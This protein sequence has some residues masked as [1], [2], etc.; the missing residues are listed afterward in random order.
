MTFGRPTLFF[1]TMSAPNAE[2]TR[3]R[4]E[5]E[6]TLAAKLRLEA[7]LDA[8]EARLRA[9]HV[10]LKVSDKE[11]VLAHERLEE[12]RAQLAEAQARADGRDTDALALLNARLQSAEAANAAT[13]A[14]ID[15]RE[16]HVHQLMKDMAKL[17]GSAACDNP[18]VRI[19]VEAYELEQRAPQLQAELEQKYEQLQFAQASVAQLE[20]TVAESVPRT[21]HTNLQQELD[22][23]RAQLQAVSASEQAKVIAINNLA[24]DKE[25]SEKRIVELEDQLAA[26][27]ANLRALEGTLAHAN[28]EIAR[29][30]DYGRTKAGETDRLSHDLAVQINQFA[31]LEQYCRD[32]EYDI[33][34][35]QD[36]YS[37]TVVQ[38][39]HSLSQLADERN[40]ALDEVDQL[41]RMNERMRLDYADR[42][43][44]TH[45]ELGAAQVENAKLRAQAKK[46]ELELEEAH[47]DLVQAKLDAVR[48]QARYTE[49]SERAERLQFLVDELESRLQQSAA[50]A[51]SAELQVRKLESQ[52]TAT[53]TELS[54]QKNERREEVERYE[55]DLEKK[56]S[57]LFVAL[58][59]AALLI[60]E[61]RRAEDRY[62]EMMSAQSYTMEKKEKQIQTLSDEVRKL[63]N[64]AAELRIE[65]DEAERKFAALER[66]K[67]LDLQPA[68]QMLISVE[69]EREEL[70][71]QRVRANAAISS[72]EQRQNSLFRSVEKL[73]RQISMLPGGF[74]H[75]E[76]KDRRN[77]QNSREGNGNGGGLLR[78]VMTAVAG[79]KLRVE[80]QSRVEPQPSV[81]DSFTKSG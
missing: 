7:Q 79:R 27:R 28:Q 47:T 57:A 54:Q 48:L 34:A 14:Q 39:E 24:L 62:R 29:L 1:G 42:T 4:V 45:A 35:L 60:D 18:Q 49:L 2:A 58:E 22:A 12:L 17:A 46:R 66:K 3:L 53:Q 70:R 55:L 31:A 33:A 26:A 19:L 9:L 43:A 71:K 16:R 50:R 30:S 11:L 80:P 73:Q 76:L 78:F 67:S 51:C 38:L 21:T 56:E 52:V 8:S 25:R 23:I 63:R 40:R 13:L 69:M 68:T 44:T 41:R 64:E 81:D 65:K 72:A 74:D 15:A 37:L 20:K 5:L 61:K 10:D 75:K 59:K 36:H 32:I 6:R 77:T